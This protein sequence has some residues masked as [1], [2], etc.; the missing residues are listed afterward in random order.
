MARARGLLL[1]PLGAV[2]SQIQI[3]M[4]SELDWRFDLDP[5]I[6]TG[7][8]YSHLPLALPQKVG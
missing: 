7:L 5:H 4:R 3:G 1:A 8:V 6:R 2:E